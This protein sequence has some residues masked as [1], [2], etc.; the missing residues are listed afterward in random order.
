MVGLV[1]EKGVSAV[2][3]QVDVVTIGTFGPPM[4]SSAPTSTFSSPPPRSSKCEGGRI[5][6]NDVSVYTGWAAADLYLS[7]IVMSNNDPRNA[8]YPGLFKYDD[9]GHIIEELISGKKV[10]LVWLRPTVPTATRAR[11]TAWRWA[12]PISTAWCS[13]TRA[14]PTSSTTWR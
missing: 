10:R 4:C 8:V 12:W 9:G 2:A 6:F 11:N 13:S 1:A 5:T 3:Q 7:C 14:T